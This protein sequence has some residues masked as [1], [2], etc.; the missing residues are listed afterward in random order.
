[1]SRRPTPTAAAILHI[2]GLFCLMGSYFLQVSDDV[3][4]PYFEI[5]FA[6]IVDLIL[7]ET[8]RKDGLQVSD[9]LIGN[10]WNL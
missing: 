10:V 1:M 8:V 9:D 7:G 4:L 3:L 5:G 2:E 6:E